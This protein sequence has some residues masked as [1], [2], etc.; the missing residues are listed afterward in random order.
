MPAAA[1]GCGSVLKIT[2]DGRITTILNTTSPWSPTGVAVSGN[3]IYV[4][5]YLHTVGDTRREWLPR[6][7]KLLPDGSIATIAEIKER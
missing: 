3:D 7:R 1:S 2:T 4:L 5:E 6:V